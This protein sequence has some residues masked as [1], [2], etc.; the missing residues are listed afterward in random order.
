MATI[1]VWTTAHC[2]MCTAT[3]RILDTKGIDYETRRLEDHP[4]Q[5][6]AFKSEGITQAPIVVT[7]TDHWA[8]HRPDKLI[9][10]TA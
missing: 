7:E 10:L 8:G 4:D 9:S 5:L 6:E 1:T 2:T 3:T